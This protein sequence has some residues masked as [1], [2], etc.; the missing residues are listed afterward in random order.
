M[1]IYSD[2][3]ISSVVLKFVN[4]YSFGDFNKVNFALQFY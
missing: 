1:K 4:L 2:I 3:Y